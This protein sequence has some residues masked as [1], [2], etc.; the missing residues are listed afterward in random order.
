LRESK[1][2]A[3]RALPS[4]ERIHTFYEG[5]SEWHGAAAAQRG[6]I[7]ASRRDVL[8]PRLRRSEVGSRRAIWDRT[9][10]PPRDGF[11]CERK[12]SNGSLGRLLLTA[13]CRNNR[14]LLHVSVAL[15]LGSA[16]QRRRSKPR[17]LPVYSRRQNK[18]PAR[19]RLIARRR[20]GRLWELSSPFAS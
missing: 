1:L 6:S 8:A 18:W 12:F 9:E 7:C 15:R 14:R 5:N 19:V 17:A 16:S 20:S 4:G 10:S 3:D 2:S 11:V 13:P